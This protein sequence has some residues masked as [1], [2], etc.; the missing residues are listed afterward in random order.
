MEN[1]LSLTD[2]RARIL[3]LL[4]TNGKV[5]V[6]ELSAR[7]DVSEVCIRN[8]LTELENEGQLARVHGG[9]VSSYSSYYHMSLAQR[10]NT[11]RGGKESIANTIADMVRDHQTVIMNAGT[12]TLEVMRKLAKKKEITIVTNS[13][14]L[15]L[16][17]AKHKNLHIILLGGE[18]DYEYQYVYGT[19]TMKQLRDFYADWLILSVDGIDA[20]FGLSTYYDKEADISRQMIDQAKQT[21]AAADHTKI[22]RVTFCNI[23]KANAVDCVVTTPEADQDVIR[24]LEN[25][26][27]QIIYSGRSE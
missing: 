3:E 9:A 4:R 7:F 23:A 27:I 10:L 17:G 22:G 8:D 12:T 13:V 2:R 18:V 6:S 26:G 25:E 5:K 1:D 20:K 24:E 19:I 14:V 11:N 16:E 15:A 21:V